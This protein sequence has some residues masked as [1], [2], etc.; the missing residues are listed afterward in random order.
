MKDSYTEKVI[1]ELEA[2]IEKIKI[3]LLS[4][5]SCHKSSPDLYNALNNALK[6]LELIN[7]VGVSKNKE[8]V[9]GLSLEAFQ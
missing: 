9:L 5:E 6:E 2:S 8:I 1:T 7:R 4:L 3:E